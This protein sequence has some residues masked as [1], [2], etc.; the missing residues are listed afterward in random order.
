MS[1]V[2]IVKTESYEYCK[3]YSSMKKLIEATSF[4]VVS[5]K[6]VLIKTNLLS[7]TEYNRH[8]TTHPEVIRA[9]IKIVKEKGAKSVLVGDSPGLHKASFLP[10]KSGIMDVIEETGSTW[11][12]FTKNPVTRTI[13]K[14]TKVPVASVL[15]EAD[16]VI[17]AAKFKTHQLMLATGAVKN[18]FGVLP[19][20]NKSKMHL[21]AQSPEEFSKLLISVFSLRPADYA[22]MDA[23]VGMEGAGP[24]NGTPRPISLLLG[25]SD[26]FSLDVAQ[27]IIMGYGKEDVPLLNQARKD[28]LLPGDQTY[29]LLKAEDLVIPSFDRIKVDKKGLLKSLVLPVFT[30]NRDRRKQQNKPAPTFLRDKC[31]L[32]QK[33]VEICPAKALNVEN[34]TIVIDKTRCIRCYCC[35]EMC[36]FD[37]IEIQ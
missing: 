19:G 14:N 36:P 16:V 20:L 9:L 8:V 18:M 11:V 31:R 10:L 4:P 12:D 29:P 32:C 13:Y 22:I 35:H 7:D 21:I 34:K 30:K 1:E 33:C 15:F 3:V 27:S 6:S 25:S 5:G 2:A 26:A 28:G 17:S 37:A 24:S 23:I